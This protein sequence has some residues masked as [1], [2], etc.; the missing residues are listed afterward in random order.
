MLKVVEKTKLWFGISLTL[1]AIGLIFFILNKGLNTGVDFSGGTVVRIE[2]GEASKTA[3]KAEIDN[4]INKYSTGTPSRTVNETQIEIQSNQLDNEKATELF[5]EI[6]EKYSLDDTALV[7]VKHIDASIG[8]ETTRNALVALLVAA[9][10]MLIYI[11]FRFK[12][13]KF[14]LAAI[15]ALIH[16]V[17]IT[18]SLYAV[19]RISVNASFI[20]AILTIVGYSINDTIVI[21]DRIRENSKKLRGKTVAEIADIS[22]NESMRRSI[23]TSLTTLLTITA[24]YIFVPSVREFSLPIIAGVIAGTYSSIFIASPLWVIFK[25]ISKKKKVATA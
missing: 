4:I 7:D 21:F 24:V 19:L 1:I 18:I 8:K 10:F 12:D 11:R 17:L 2:L 5:N 22:I 9:L 25:N 20:A 3:D 23:N 13:L 16:D 14:G 6:K 15:I